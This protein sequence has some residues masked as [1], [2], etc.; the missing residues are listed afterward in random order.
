MDRHGNRR[1]LLDGLPSAR[2]FV[3]DFN[4]TTGVY[5]QG[6]TL[7]ILNGQGDVTLPGPV[8]GTERANSAPASPIF[9]SVLAVH[10]SDAQSAAVRP[11][12]IENVPTSIRWAGH[13]LLV[14]LLS[15]A[16]S[17]LPGYS[18]V[19]Q[20][21]PRTGAITP[22]IPGP[23]A[24]IDVIPLRSHGC[25]EGSLTLEFDLTFPAPC[26]RPRASGNS[27]PDPDLCL[28]ASA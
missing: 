4:G 28:R 20:V 9:S 19:Q 26:R 1:T 18:Q 13:D 14:T 16:P 15:G 3:G 5:L 2:T 7:F 27:F 11:P 17:F 8:Q 6:R 23:S 24:A 22:L 12:V 21:D 10:F 25:G